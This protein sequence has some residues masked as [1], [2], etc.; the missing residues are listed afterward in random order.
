MGYEN[1]TEMRMLFTVG[2]ENVTC[3]L[4]EDESVLEGYWTETLAKS[5]T[6]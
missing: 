3:Q 1:E 6:V 4:N 5:V 2:Y